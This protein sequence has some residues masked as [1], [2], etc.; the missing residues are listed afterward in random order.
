MSSRP[1]THTAG[2]QC[3]WCSLPFAQRF[4]VESALI[5]GQ[6]I[7]PERVVKSAH[8]EAYRLML[9]LADSGVDL[10]QADLKN[11]QK[12]IGGEQHLWRDRALSLDELG[13]Y[14]DWNIGLSMSD[15]SIK[16]IGAEWTKV[17]DEMDDLWDLLWQKSRGWTGNPA[18]LDRSPIEKAAVIH[19]MYERIHPFPDGN[20]RSGRLLALF[21]LR[22]AK[23]PPVLFTNWDKGTEYYPAFGTSNPDQM[24]A[25]FKTHQDEW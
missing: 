25:Y 18:W 2:Y 3:P 21:M 4:V 14:R 10:T 23:V 1:H 17:Q 8:M 6:V 11:W 22:Q 12:L 9:L 16:N 5:E 19:H 24:I 15:G 7:P 20:G 13:Q